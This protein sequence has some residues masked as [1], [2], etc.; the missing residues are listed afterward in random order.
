MHLIA[1]V[2][3]SLFVEVLGV[4]K[5]NGA[6]GGAYT[7]TFKRGFARV[8]FPFSLGRSD[9][10]NH[11]AVRSLADRDYHSGDEYNC[12]LT[13]RRLAYLDRSGRFFGWQKCSTTGIER[14]RNPMTEFEKTSQM[15]TKKR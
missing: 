15:T 5:F 13:K 4:V 3:S 6:N 9:Q 8:L 11:H 10:S 1:I 12:C 7:E 14:F 2:L